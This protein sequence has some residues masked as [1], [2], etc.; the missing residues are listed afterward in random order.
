MQP[1]WRPPRPWDRSQAPRW[2]SCGTGAM[3][4]V[5][6]LCVT[7][8]LVTIGTDMMSEHHSWDGGFQLWPP[9]SENPGAELLVGCQPAKS[10]WLGA[11]MPVPGC[12]NPSLARLVPCM[13]G[14]PHLAAAGRRSRSPKSSPRSRGERRLLRVPWQR[15]QKWRVSWRRSSAWGCGRA[16]GASRALACWPHSSRPGVSA[17]E[18]KKEKKDQFG[19]S[20]HPLASHGSPA[21]ASTHGMSCGRSL[22]PT[23]SQKN[24]TSTSPP[25]TMT[26]SLQPIPSH[27]QA[28]G[29]VG[30]PGSTG[31]A[32]VMPWG[33]QPPLAGGCQPHLPTH[34]TPDQIVGRL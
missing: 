16:G 34:T 25:K 21:P 8:C 7:S 13:V 18:G 5:P 31:H 29:H 1:P 24:L 3:L 19:R 22:L 4:R 28:V 32:E 15:R 12:G 27:R 26:V 9:P 30:T 23:E 10:A 33:S 20:G 2:I 14:V 11:S 17:A 6:V